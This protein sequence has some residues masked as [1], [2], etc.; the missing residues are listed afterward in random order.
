MLLKYFTANAVW[1]V[2]SYIFILSSLFL[3][4]LSDDV[5]YFQCSLDETS[6]FLFENFLQILKRYVRSNYT[7]LAQVVKRVYELEEINMTALKKEI[8][9]TIKT[10]DNNRVFDCQMENMHV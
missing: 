5:K 6:C 7:P 1:F 10:N 8:K 3:N 2:W 9:T 4:P